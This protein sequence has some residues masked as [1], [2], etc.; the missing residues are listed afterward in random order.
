MFH[1]VCRSCVLLVRWLSHLDDDAGGDKWFAVLKLY[2]LT[3]T[4]L[5]ISV[6][7][8]S[9]SARRTSDVVRF[10]AAVTLGTRS[11]LLL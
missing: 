9:C 1:Y 6:W 2:N 3:E 5:S 10:A 11:K 8:A 7:R 4:V